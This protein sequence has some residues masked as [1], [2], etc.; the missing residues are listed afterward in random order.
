MSVWTYQLPRQVR[1]RGAKKASWYV[2]WFT[3]EGKKRGKSCG[4]GFLGKAKAEKERQRIESELESGKYRE[5]LKR[6]WKDFKAEYAARILEGMTSTTR[7]VTLD[8]LS[9]FERIVQPVRMFRIRT[10]DFD[11][12]V[13]ARR[14]EHGKKRGSLVSPATINKELRHLK[15]VMRVAEDWGYLPAMPKV[16]MEKVPKKLPTYVTGEHFAAIYRACEH[17]KFPNDQPFPA[18][19]WWRGLVVTGYMT[20]WRVSDMLGLRRI[21]TDLDAGTAIT[22]YEDNKGKRDELVKLHPVVVAHLR[23]LTPAGRQGLKLAGFDPCLFPWNWSRRRL[24]E[25]FARI[26]QKA[27]IRLPCRVRGEHEHTPFCYVYGFHDLRR[28]FATMNAD[29]L[30]ASALQALMRHKSYQTT[31]LYI[32][33][34]RQMDEAVASLH[35][36]EVLRAME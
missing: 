22:R 2:G 24:H 29:K 36:P 15:A 12:Y 20:G 32:N 17:A 18:A 27:G 21:D 26:Q 23:K 33:M 13:A 9:H 10:Q 3:P 34:A 11:D 5:Q 35:V 7:R 19:D 1:E 28:A 25:Q 6:T 14:Q 8:A 4:A 16:R 30:S 31:Q